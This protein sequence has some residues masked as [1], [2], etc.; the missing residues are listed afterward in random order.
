[1]LTGGG[2]IFVILDMVI[3]ILKCSK[4]LM[5]IFGKDQ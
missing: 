5:L 1:M 3:N 2:Y 4:N